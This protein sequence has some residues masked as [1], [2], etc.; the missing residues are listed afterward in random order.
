MKE[1]FECGECG[2]FFYKYKS[3]RPKF[4]SVKCKTKHQK[5]LTG[6]NSP[7]WKGYNNY[8][9][10]C[11]LCKEKFIGNKERVFCSL[12]CKSKFFVSEKFWN[13]DKTGSN[14]PNWK[15]D[16]LFKMC[17][18]C[19][20]DFRAKRMNQKFCSKFCF[21]VSVSLRLSNK[22]HKYNAA[23]LNS[24]IEN[25]SKP[26]VKLFDMIMEIDNKAILNYPVGIFSID[27]ALPDKKIAFEYDSTYWHNIKYDEW[28]QKQLENDGWIFIRYKDCIPNISKLKND[29]WEKEKEVLLKEKYVNA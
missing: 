21:G 3:Q 17:P 20:I 2:E 5:T 9:H 29:L 23:Y 12:S 1:Q 8:T 24:F 28:R 27:I 16:L 7:N 15:G 4:C 19:F 18:I 11:K 14:N 22:N 6:I 25:P 10:K 13:R 26:Q